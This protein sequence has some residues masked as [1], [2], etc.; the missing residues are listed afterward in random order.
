M[1]KSQKVK[2][3]KIISFQPKLLPDESFGKVLT[4]IKNEYSDGHPTTSP[5]I[6]QIFQSQMRERSQHHQLHHH[7]LKHQQKMRRHTDNQLPRLPWSAL[8]VCVLLVVG[9]V[10]GGRF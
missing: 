4:E 2:K 10:G 7:L 9:W 8:K 5:A 3:S 1:S 6:N